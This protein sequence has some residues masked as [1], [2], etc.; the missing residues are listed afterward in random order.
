MQ[1]TT[2]FH[3]ATSRRRTILTLIDYFAQEALKASEAGNA[4]C[5]TTELC[6]F[7]DQ[8][9]SDDELFNVYRSLVNV[10]PPMEVPPEIGSVQ[11]DFLK[12]ET[13][14]KG[15]VDAEALFSAAGTSPDSCQGVAVWKGDITTLKIGAIVNAAN[16]QLLGCWAPCHCCIDNCIHTFA[17]TDLRLACYK[18]MEAQG[19]E[20]PT[21][22]AKITKAYNLPCSYV[23]HTVGPIIN[24]SLTQ[25]DSDQL[26]S[27]YIS[28][29]D[30][31]AENGITSVAFCCI[32][33]GV[34][35]FPNDKACHVAVSTV[36]TWFDSHPDTPMHVLFNV[37]KDEDLLLYR[38]FC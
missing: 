13:E 16:S 3:D 18:I 17:G 14:A 8:R 1:H 28:C 11:N 30:L 21:G 37:F 22:C 38:R 12:T 9:Y 31:A 6:Y 7:D 32:S 5:D 29:L 2:E 27:C 4:W 33:T 10:R 15:I 34:F 19:H 24:S 35:H 23:L 25:K 26:A 36:R 20:E